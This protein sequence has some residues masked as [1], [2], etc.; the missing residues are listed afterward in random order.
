MMKLN[1]LHVKIQLKQLLIINVLNVHNFV[2]YVENFQMMK[3]LKLIHTSIYKALL[4]D[5]MQNNV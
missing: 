1:V 2:N 4:I 5:N 3:L